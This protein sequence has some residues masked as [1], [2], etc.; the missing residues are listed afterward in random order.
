MEDSVSS[1]SAFV[2]QFV[3]ALQL[4][5]GRIR[6]ASLDETRE[7]LRLAAAL[8]PADLGPLAF[9]IIRDLFTRAVLEALAC[10][11]V[12]GSVSR[13]SLAIC[14]AHDVPSLL[15]AVEQV[16][17]ALPN[18]SNESGASAV[19]DRRV[20]R[21]V[22]CIREQCTQP[23]LSLDRVAEH[24]QLSKWYLSRLIARDTGM[25]YR[26]LVVNGRM[27]QATRLLADELLTVKEVSAR[28]G[29]ASST[30][31]HRQFKQRFGVTP[32]QWRVRHR[33]AS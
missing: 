14:H 19:Q 10:R 22:R 13:E 17:D 3:R 26:E 30:E 1:D 28:L 4:F 12:T 11:S 21:A 9:C 18:P 7:C 2:Q 5:A 29:Y 33:R 24:V 15:A 6:T 31:F 32:T 8:V 23:S 25:A 20:I 27:E 16:L